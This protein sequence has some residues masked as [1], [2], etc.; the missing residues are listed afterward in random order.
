MLIE[1]LC[2]DPL[3]VLQIVG[4]GPAFEAGELHKE[5]S[6]IRFDLSARQNEAIYLGM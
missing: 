5:E 6:R 2:C 4:V 3:L 1:V